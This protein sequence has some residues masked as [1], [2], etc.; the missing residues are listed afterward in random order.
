MFIKRQRVQLDWHGKGGEGGRAEG[1][2]CKG[3]LQEG[4]QGGMT[5]HGIAGQLLFEL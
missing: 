1:G 2:G 4:M 3:G 5:I